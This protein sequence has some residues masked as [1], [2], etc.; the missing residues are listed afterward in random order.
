MLKLPAIDRRDVPEN[1]K[2]AEEPLPS[3]TQ[4][5]NSNEEK[6]SSEGSDDSQAS[7]ERRP[8]DV[9]DEASDSLQDMLDP[10]KRTLEAATSDISRLNA[11]AGLP[12]GTE[13][14]LHYHDQA[15][16]PISQPSFDMKATAAASFEADDE[17]P[18][19]ESYRLSLDFNEQPLSY[20]EELL[21]LRS[22][23]VL[24]RSRKSTEK[25]KDIMVTLKF[26]A[27]DQPSVETEV[28]DIGDRVQV[29]NS[30]I[31][32]CLMV[33]EPLRDQKK[34]AAF[35]NSEVDVMI[36]GFSVSLDE[37]N[38]QFG[39]FDITPMGLHA[40]LKAWHNLC[41]SFEKQYSCSIFEH[42]ALCCRFGQ[43]LRANLEAG[44]LSSPESNLLRTRVLQF[45]Q[46]TAPRTT[47]TSPA[48]PS[49]PS[50]PQKRRAF[51]FV[52]SPSRFTRS[53]VGLV[54]D[55]NVVDQDSNTQSTRYTRGV[56][57]IAP[58]AQESSI[59]DYA[60][61]FDSLETDESS[62]SSEQLS[63]DS[64]LADSGSSPLGEINWLW[65]C[66]ADLIP[67]FVATPWRKL[68]PEAVCI[69]AISV[70]LDVLESFTN[71]SNCRYVESQD[72][73]RSWIDTGKSSFPGYAHNADGGVVASGIYECV[74]F[75]CLNGGMPPI[76]LLYS[77]N[78]QVDRVYYQSTLHVKDS[79][80]E[81][82]GLDSWLSICSRLPE[83]SE[84]RSNLLRVLPSLIQRTMTEFDL[85]FSS[86]DRTSRD[87]GLRIIQTIGE[88]LLQ[89][90][91][92]QNLSAAEQFFASV[93]MIR[94][95]KFGLCVARGIDTS[96]LRD[97]IVHDVQVYMA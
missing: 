30:I 64:T 57:A 68:F 71:S 9:D 69:G 92:D 73:C 47:S 62:S 22:E 88:S 27:N 80:G 23:S 31:K 95:V 96:Q 63:N 86:L 48:S 16:R 76:E 40:R 41:S 43:E 51:R 78:H 72:R 32:Q 65:I 18:T 39:L 87:G 14:P 52:Q 66:Q 60:R 75:A 67:G 83:I 94:T 82:V 55:E 84:G 74:N 93:A 81:L 20:E 28:N 89:S 5:A 25:C 10:P 36:C 79:L 17:Q 26:F 45:S 19:N 1:D 90:F 91:Q 61:E 33:I 6:I 3:S 11:D 49:E 50:V 38:D 37:L 12:H 42:L 4:S 34:L 77:Y 8:N 56:E 54:N 53:P 7:S 2:R 29:C 21:F 97:I 59:R 46:L 13:M 44:I 58:K 24:K 35:I 15:R 70:L 85:E